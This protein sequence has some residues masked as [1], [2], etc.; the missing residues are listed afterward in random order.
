MKIGKLIIIGFLLLSIISITALSIPVTSYFHKNA[1]EKELQNY[2]DEWKKEEYAN[3]NCR[4][5]SNAVEDYLEKKGYNVINIYG[6]GEY[7]HRWLLVQVNDVWEEFESTCL[8]FQD[9]SKKY[10]GIVA[11]YNPLLEVQ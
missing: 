9:T 8:N 3:W 10:S 4:D 2:F 6:H 5:K 11:T 1:I 7:N